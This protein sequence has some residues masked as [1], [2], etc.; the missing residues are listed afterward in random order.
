MHVIP[1][2]YVFKVKKDVGSKACTVVKEFR[3]VHGEDY[4]E[5]VAPVV[6]IDT[7]PCLSGN[8]CTF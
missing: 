8:I 6:S 7:F 2:R 1:C 4:T 3:Q 5:N